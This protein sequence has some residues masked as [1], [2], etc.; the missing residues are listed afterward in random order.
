MLHR[1]PIQL[2][3]LKFVEFAKSTVNW[4]M[5]YASARFFLLLFI[6]N[7]KKVKLNLKG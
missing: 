3:V 5:C 6:G 2:S 7:E 4:P 1:A